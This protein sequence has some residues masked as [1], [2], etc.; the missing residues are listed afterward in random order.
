M[1]IE[2]FTCLDFETTA[3]SPQHA[4]IVQVGVVNF[5]LQ[6]VNS[7]WRM[8]TRSATLVDPGVAIP[9]E[10]THVHDIDDAA[11]IC[12]RTTLQMLPTLLQQLHNSV[13]VG[14]NIIDYDLACLQ[15]E[16]RRHGLASEFVATMRSLQGVVDVMPWAA[17]TSRA[18]QFRRGARTL[19]TMARL[20]G[21][22]TFGAHDAG[23]DAEATGHL[24]LSLIASDHMPQL[25]EVVEAMSSTWQHYKR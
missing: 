25:D 1:A 3:R 16:C 9:K 21:V 5:E 17:R 22:G 18:P 15:A 4:R 8:C 10:A 20:H 24:L 14:Y 19:A 23:A 2:R 7:E 11:V 13:L 12:A 6:A